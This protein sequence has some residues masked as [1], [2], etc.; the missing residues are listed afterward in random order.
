MV[1]GEGILR[2]LDVLGGH[3]RVLLVLEDLQ[4]AD[5]ESLTVLEYLVTPQKSW[6]TVEQRQGWNLRRG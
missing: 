3:S 6:W 2:M 1:L 5:P 4:W